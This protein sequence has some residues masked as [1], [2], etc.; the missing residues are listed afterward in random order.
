MATV[1]KLPVHTP[2]S[3][4]LPLFRFGLRQLFSFVAAVSVLFA[5]LVSFGGLAALV[6]ILFVLVVIMHVFATTL[7]GR[8]RARADREH[9]FEA[10]D[11]LPIE[12]IATRTERRERLAAV[13]AGPRSPWHDRG[14]T[15]LPW[16]KKLVIAAIACGAIV[17]TVY[18][19]VAIGYRT[20]PAGI[21]VGG[22][23]VAVLFGWFAFLLGSFYGVFRHG[24]RDAVAGEKINSPP[25]RPGD[26]PG[27]ARLFDEPP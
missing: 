10:S 26:R 4:D 15:I 21:V 19:A 2:D 7:G 14:S 1:E 11:R 13:Q 25:V 9:Q 3:V 18:L 20:S 22:V 24:F 27:T 16:L 17:G 12:S 8:L 23:S 5:A 6:L